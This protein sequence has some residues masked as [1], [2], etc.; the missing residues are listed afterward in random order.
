[1]NAF[2]AIILGAVEGLTEFLPVSSSAHLTLLPWV[3]GWEDPGLTF[4]VAL[5]IGTLAAVVSCFWRDWL[6]ILRGAA[7]DRRGAQARFLGLLVLA[8]LPAVAAGLILEDQAEHAFRQPWRIATAL[9]GFAV[10]MELADRWGSKK[11]AIDGL[12]LSGAV[13]IGLA[14]ALSICPGVSR[15]GVT[16]TAGLALG[17]SRSEAARYSFLLSTPITAGACLLKLRHLQIGDA[18]GPF[19]WGI[20][21]SAVMGFAAVRFFLANLGSLSLRPYV[22]YRLLA[23]GAILWAAAS[24]FRA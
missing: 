5:H 19:L 9:M 10:L 14:Q 6:D 21:V 16:L 8:T 23:G 22:V 15:S 11:R 18:S 4:D 2:E 3:L 20:A 1:M 24:G 7:R 12:G 17:L 13:G